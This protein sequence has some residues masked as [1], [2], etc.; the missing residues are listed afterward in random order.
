MSIGTGANKVKVVLDT[1]V[2]ISAVVFGGKPRE[3]LNLIIN[4]RI[5]AVTTPVLLAE[6]QDVVSKKFPLLAINIKKIDKQI[7][8]QFKI[9]NPKKTL[10]IL[11]DEPD[12][13]VLE[14][15]IEGNCQ[16]IVTGDKG[17]V[18]L[19]KYKNI[20]ILKPDQFILSL[21]EI[22]KKQ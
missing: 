11:K 14:A 7:R 21:R 1:N 3:I 2:I 16:Y 15:A 4:K 12:N 19:R 20:R 13:R 17:L 8:K 5:Q 9:V 10:K 18:E 22:T 6:F